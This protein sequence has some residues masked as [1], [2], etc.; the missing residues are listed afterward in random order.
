MVRAILDGRK[1]MTR[2][3]I[4]N[5]PAI[6]MYPQIKDA[7]VPIL[8]LIEAYKKAWLTVCPYGQPGDRLWVRE[9]WASW[10]GPMGILGAIHKVGQDEQGQVSIKWHSPIFMP[11]WASRITLEITAVRV[12]RVQDIT[13]AD[14]EA[15]GFVSVSYRDAPKGSIGY[16]AQIAVARIAI[17]QF[18]KYW[19]FLNAKRGY[20]WDANPWVW[21]ISFE[22]KLKKGKGKT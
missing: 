22:A 12:E 10:T 2:R 18:A 8:E 5:V 19:D 16:P 9:T 7:G 20:G 15:E 14:A 17:G 4:K 1:T 11:R 6:L 13:A 3:V 21:V